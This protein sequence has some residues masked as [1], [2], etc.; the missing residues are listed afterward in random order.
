MT[1][2]EYCRQKSAYTGSNLYYS[3][4]FTHNEAKQALI[5]LHALKCELNEINKNGTS[6]DI[7]RT[8]LNWWREEIERLYNSNPTHPVSRA[9]S[10]PIHQFNLRQD[11]FREMIAGA[12][13]NLNYDSYP[14][15]TELSFYC[16]RTAGVVEL[17]IAGVLGYKNPK[18][19]KYASDLGHALA[20]TSIVRNVRK[21]AIR[22]YIYIP[23]DELEEFNVS[24]EEL[25]NGHTE[26]KMRNL[27]AFQIN[28]AQEYYQQAL[29]SLPEEDRGNQQS[30]LIRAALYQKLL[31]EIER[32]SYR[33]LEHR[34]FLTPIRKLWIAWK[35]SRNE[36][37]R[38]PQQRD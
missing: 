34:I 36:Q 15:F 23:L 4:L 26:K 25:Q 31:D 22:G 27:F 12:E 5:A 18:T 24:P 37:R 2:E 3:T 35:T 32:D 7:A 30:S 38:Y 16:Y 20:L 9:L 8:K 10:H 13:M 1:P 33:V 29:A 28:R 6:V 17:L 11:H 19:E 14:S 21:H